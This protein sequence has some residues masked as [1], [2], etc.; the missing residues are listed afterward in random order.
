M[1]FTGGSS[2][3]CSV[4]VVRRFDITAELQ[5]SDVG[6]NALKGHQTT[7]L[8]GGWFTRL[9]H[10]SQLFPE[11]RCV[12]KRKQQAPCAAGAMRSRRH[13]HT[14]ANMCYA[15]PL[16]PSTPPPPTHT[17]LSPAGRAWCSPWRS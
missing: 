8:K 5:Q 4:I 16:P 12:G 17:Q 15:S 13:A 1:G 6:L 14:F 2:C 10:F 3:D 9:L 7:L 11:V